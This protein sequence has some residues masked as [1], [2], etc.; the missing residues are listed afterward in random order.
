[1]ARSGWLQVKEN[2]ANCGYC[3][4]YKRRENWIIVLAQESQKAKQGKKWNRET[5]G[6]KGTNKGTKGKNMY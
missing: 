2:G 3:L 5:E 6:K 4:L 1:M